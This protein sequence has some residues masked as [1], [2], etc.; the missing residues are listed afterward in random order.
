MET[1]PP[2]DPET[3][4]PGLLYERL[5]DTAARADL[6]RMV[7]EMRRTLESVSTDVRSLREERARTEGSS[8]V[9]RALGGIAATA[10][11]AGSGWALT[12]GSQAAAD[13]DRVAE[14]EARFVRAEARFD[15]Q[16]DDLDDIRESLV[17]VETLLDQR[18]RQDEE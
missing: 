16:D 15:S 8:R 6:G 10:A 14:H 18:A 2:S 9:W 13:H 7:R 12:L 1:E 11:L 17:R 4:T 5:D 3:P